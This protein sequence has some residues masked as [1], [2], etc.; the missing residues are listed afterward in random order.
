M[1]KLSVLPRMKFNNWRLPLE[2]FGIAT[3]AGSAVLFV[4]ISWRKWPDPLIDFGEQLYSAWRLSEGAV[5]YRDVEL[6]YGPFS[7]YFN[8]VIFRIFGPGLIVL[9][10]VNL[11]VFAGI[12]SSIY[13]LFR[14]TWGILA[15]WLSTLIFISVFG[16]SQFVDAGNYNYAGPYSHETIHGVL[17]CLLLCFALVRWVENAKGRTG[18]LAGSLF[19]LTIILKPEFIVAAALATS[20]AIAVV[21]RCEGA[22][23]T[24]ALTG[25]A[26]GVVLPTALFSCYF[27][28]FMPWTQAFS[29]SSRAWLN[30]LDTSLT[31]DPLQTRLLGFDRPW[32]NLIDHATATSLAALV[33]L[34]IAFM[35]W[36]A[37]REQ[38]RWRFLIAAGAMMLGLAWL[39]CRVINWIEI[40][41]CFFGLALIYATVSVFFFFSGSREQQD[42]GKFLARILIA[43]VAI[44]LMARM[45]LNGRIYHYGYYQAALA[46]VLVPAVMVAELPSWLR[47]NAAGYAFAAVATL[48]LILPGVVNLAHRS[49]RGWA[50]KTQAVGDGRDRFYC[51][52]R[53]MDSIGEVVGAVTQALREKGENKSLTVLPEGEFIN[54]LARLP[55]PLPHAFFYAGAISNGREAQ[56]VN[57]LEGKPPYWI[58]IISRDLFGYGIERYGEKTGSGQEILHWVGQNYKQVASIGGDPL[59]YRERGAI[60]LRKY[61]R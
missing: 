52:P 25:W 53:Q 49:E 3:L 38:K 33:I 9:A 45:M 2:T 8:A 4:T 46:G 39:A 14:R 50:L 61:A 5:L 11:L 44:A 21:W 59:D 55:N 17:V 56:L 58:V 26:T 10:I 42:V 16:L 32:V 27:A 60:I 40:G 18:F 31:T 37:N 29:A 1:R 24:V 15:A 28:Q 41:R 19:G 34:A 6:L 54:Y 20:I 7:E 12:S 30:A 35:V 43:V 47:A 23:R 13:I 36:L 57:E 22:P 51:F 48:V